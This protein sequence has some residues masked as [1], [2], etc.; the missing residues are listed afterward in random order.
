MRQHILRAVAFALFQALAYAYDGR[1]PGF[2]RRAGPLR[3]GLIGLAEVL[4]PFAVTDQARE[5][6]R[7]P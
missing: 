7:C 2:E 3:D 4:P 6:R 1:E 5:W